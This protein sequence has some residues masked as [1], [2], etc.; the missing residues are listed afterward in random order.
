MPDI[1]ELPEGL[2]GGFEVVDQSGTV[3][4]KTWRLRHVET[5]VEYRLTPA[6]VTGRS[7]PH[8]AES[9]A[10]SI[11]VSMEGRSMVAMHLPTG[12]V[13]TTSSPPTAVR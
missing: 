2:T 13:Y 3:G 8:R 10:P 1:A 4:R 5:G 9:I 11:I 7:M 12:E 6:T